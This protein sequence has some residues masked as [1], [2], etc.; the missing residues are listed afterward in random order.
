MKQIHLFLLILLTSNL[1]VRA[2]EKKEQ[3]PQNYFRAPLDLAP[4]A[5]GTFGELRSNHFHT[6]TDYRTNQREGYPVYAVADGFISRARVQIGGGGN[7]LYIDHPNG[8]TSVYMH[9]Q[10]YNKTI[11]HV[12]RAKQYEL[13]SFAVDF[14][15]GKN[16]IP[17]KK[18]EIIAYSGNT[19]GSGGPHLHFEIRETKSEQALNPQLFGLTIPDAVPPIINGFTVFRLGD[20]PFSENTP[21]EHLQVVGSNGKYRLS[22]TN[23]INVNGL[24]GFGVVS[25]DQSSVSAN[26]NGLYSVEL[27]LDGEL[28][29][30]AYFSGIFFH[31]NRA[32][33]SYIDYPTYI[34]NGRRIQKGFV[35][36]GN[37]LTIYKNLVNNG[38][39]KI[40]DDMVHEMS[41][42]VK[43]IKGNTSMLSFPVKYSPSLQISQTKHD[44]G[45]LW[46]FNQVNE[47]KHEDVSVELP[48][49]SLYS[50]LNFIYTKSARRAN[51][52]SDVHNIHNRMIPLHNSYSL[53]IKAHSDL[54]VH[55]YSKA[56]LLDTR[57]RAH[58]GSFENGFVTG[59]VREL[60]S[61]YIGVDTQ[62]PTIRPLNISENKS[63]A[64]ISQINFKISDNLSGIKSFNGYINDK[65]VLMEYDAKTASLWHILASDMPKGKHT[66]RISVTDMKDN[67]KVYQVNFTR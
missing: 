8:Y 34:L 60:G 14:P 38:L 32:L 19:G 13:Q 24:T 62:A 50:D 45:Q 39:I 11:A 2:Q 46:P 25:T 37:P 29:F 36:P 51:G 23:P 7:A 6:G 10:K 16:A 57:G 30:D 66:F 43:D 53:S 56:L 17:V 64:G 41:F 54:P 18:G 3:Y 48:A 27:L 5:S 49:N 47:L 22:S 35:E 55:L 1:S 61:F 40:E 15:P 52:F 65:W 58:G 20:A 59:Q 12:I 21:R 28:I 4:Q 42:R 63:M 33:N 67:E 26:R 9:L 31:H 44:H